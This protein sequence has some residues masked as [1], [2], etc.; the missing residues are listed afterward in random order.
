MYLVLPL[1]MARA[2]TL[3]A[4]V[5]L[6]LPVNAAIA[7]RAT[8]S[9]VMSNSGEGCWS[10]ATQRCSPAITVDQIQQYNGGSTFCDNLK[11][12][13][14]VCCSSGTPPDLSPQPNADGSCYVY[15]VQPNDTCLPIADRYYTTPRQIEANNNE[16]W[17]FTDCNG[18]SVGMRICLSSG[19]PPMPSAVEGAVCG[20][21]K[22]GTQRPINGTKLADLNPCP[23]NACCDIWGQ[24]GITDEYCTDT[25]KHG[26]APGTAA[27][28]TNG[29]ISNCGT[30]I[31]NNS[32]APGSFSSVAYFEGWS[33]DRECL[34]MTPDQIDTSAY[35]HIHFAFG[36]ITD[37]FKVNISDRIGF[38]FEILARMTGVKRI[39]SFGGWSFSTEGDTWPI[40][41][42]GV[43]DANRAAFA[44]NVVDFLKSNNLDGLDF[45]WGASC[46]VFPL[47]FGPS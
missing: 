34:H 24:C 11:P 43:T 32:E 20:P 15:V 44:D 17:G 29:C 9:Y 28:N 3:V 7:P 41:R 22:P 14:P 18:L 38:Q 21:Q 36:G 23:L 25:R 16:T 8:C 47:T 6:S 35:T 39:L 40:F 46:C 1:G 31:T 30:N 37:D 4:L 5:W 19:S 10:I 27:P 12:N 2:A 13:M 45:D 26:G 42:Q 33:Y